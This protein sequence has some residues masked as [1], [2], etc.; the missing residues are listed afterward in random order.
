MSERPYDWPPAPGRVPVLLPATSGWSLQLAA[1]YCPLATGL[2]IVAAESWLLGT[3]RIVIAAY[4]RLLISAHY[5]PRHAACCRPRDTDALAAHMVFIVVALG[6][7]AKR[8]VLKSD[9]LDPLARGYQN[10]D[11]CWWRRGIQE[12]QTKKGGNS[13]KQKQNT[14]KPTNQTDRH[15]N[16]PKHYN[17]SMTYTTTPRNE[18]SSLWFG[19]TSAPKA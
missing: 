17:K 19:R 1:C 15:T 5:R 4:G 11:D 2:P 8:V 9:D 7:R 10:Y 13:P 12:P 16:R 14:N 18:V 6:S 3:H